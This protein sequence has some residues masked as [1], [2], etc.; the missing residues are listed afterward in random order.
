VKDMNSG[1]QEVCP[2]DAIAGQL[3]VKFEKS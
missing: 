1:D 3:A 2:V